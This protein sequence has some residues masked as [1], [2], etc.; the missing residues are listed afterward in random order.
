MTSSSQAIIGGF[1]HFL[2][3]FRAAATELMPITPDAG[4]LGN[5]LVWVRQTDPVDEPDEECQLF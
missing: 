3:T 4:E 2:R 5:V 1:A